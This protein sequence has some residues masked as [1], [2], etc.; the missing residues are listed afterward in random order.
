LF[1]A[2]AET[3]RQTHT[4]IIDSTHNPYLE[5]LMKP[6]QA[7]SRRFWITHVRDEEADVARGKA[8]HSEILAAILER[9]VGRAEM[10]SVALNDY[11]VGFALNTINEKV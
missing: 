9:N 8:L 4:L 7:L 3:V 5:A 2:Y 11:L 1:K 6:L 10:A